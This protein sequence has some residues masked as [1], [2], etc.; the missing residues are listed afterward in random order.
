VEPLL[1]DVHSARRFVVFQFV[2]ALLRGN[3]L[4]CTALGRS[5]GTGKAKHNIKKADR[6]LGNQHLFHEIQLFCAAICAV[7]LKDE[8]RPCL[9]VDYTDG[10]AGLI[11]L[12]AAVA[13]DGRALP[14]Y[15]E[16]H[17]ADQEG[18]PELHERFLEALQQVLP[19]GCQPLVVTDAGFRNPWFQAVL[20]RGWDFLGR[21]CS[22]VCVG[23]GAGQWATASTLHQGARRKARDLGQKTLAKGNPLSARLILIRERKPHA[24]VQ[25]RATTSRA[26]RK[27]RKRAKTPWLL[28]TSLEALSAKR[29]VALYRTRMQIEEHFRDT[30]NHRFGWS[31][32]YTGSRSAQ[33]IA[34]L[35]LLAALGT[36]ALTLVGRIG[37]MLGL[38]R[39]YQA[40]TV[41]HRRVL[42]V[43]F[44]GT[45]LL[46]HL[47]DRRLISGHRLQL[48]LRQ[49]RRLIHANS[50]EF[51][52]A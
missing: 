25:H 13:T 49:L 36:L 31:F 17:P 6:L 22:N 27:C 46:D 44:L 52:D 41:R 3:G 10:P 39:G 29:I 21:V 30:K 28:A 8:R 43:F 51:L 50:P 19:S 42:S 23:D 32:R 35:L 45:L 40:N 7:L 20:K 34:V 48:A 16:V 33:R 37:E 26:Q 14:V 9:L 4:S 24:K 47:T 2:E 18:S 12:S 15:F 1:E 5:V 38:H 11:V